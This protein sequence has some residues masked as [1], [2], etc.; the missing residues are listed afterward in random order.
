MPSAAWRNSTP[1]GPVALVSLSPVILPWASRCAVVL[2]VLVARFWASTGVRRSAG[3]L[4]VACTTG[5]PY[6]WNGR[7]PK[8]AAPLV[9]SA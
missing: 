1:S 3:P 7:V 6:S 5:L 4:A 2:I 9:V 8:G